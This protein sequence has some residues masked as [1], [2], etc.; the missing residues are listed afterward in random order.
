MGVLHCVVP[1]SYC[2]RHTLSAVRLP[3]PNAGQVP[4]CCVLPNLGLSTLPGSQPGGSCHTA[5]LSRLAADLQAAAVG[6]SF[7]GHKLTVQLKGGGSG[8]WWHRVG[9]GESTCEEGGA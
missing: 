5:A 4:S 7:W 6:Y 1:D 8:V 3:F 2:V 9:E